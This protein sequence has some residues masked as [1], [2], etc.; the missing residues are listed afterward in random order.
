MVYGLWVKVYAI[1]FIKSFFQIDDGIKVLYR[2]IAIYNISLWA[3]QKQ[4]TL[5]I[6]KIPLLSLQTQCFQGFFI[7]SNLSFKLSQIKGTKSRPFLFC[8]YTFS[9][10]L[11]PV[12]QYG[13]VWYIDYGLKFTQSVLSKVF[14]RLMMV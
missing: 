5:Q 9:K 11:Y 4:T 3:L 6:D 10:T 8:F 1:S 14:F 12:L 13:L 7:G 2:N